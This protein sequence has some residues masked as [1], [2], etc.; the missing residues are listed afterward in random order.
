MATQILGV[1][2]AGG[3]GATLRVLLSG[4]IEAV[5]VE[6]L[7]NAGVLSVNLMG[8]LLI[9]LASASISTPHWRSIILGGLLGGFTTYSAFA[10]FSVD[11]MEQQRFGVLAVQL[12]SHLIGGMLCVM[13]GMWVAQ[14]LGLANVE[15]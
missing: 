13:A 6:R 5:L 1:F 7:P 10:L 11:L 15:S 3:V 9:G 12:A 14:L 4:R 2:L 8:C